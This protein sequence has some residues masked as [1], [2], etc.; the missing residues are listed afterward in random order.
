MSVSRTKC[1]ILHWCSRQQACRNERF[2]YT[3][4]HDCSFET[5]T[6]PFSMLCAP[7]W[8]MR[9]WTN[10]GGNH[11]VVRGRDRDRRLCH[12]AVIMVQACGL[13]VASLPQHRALSFSFWWLDGIIRAGPLASARVPRCGRCFGEHFLETESGGGVGK[14]ENRSTSPFGHSQERDHGD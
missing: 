5:I 4:Q 6:G 2:K 3:Y 9:L 10:G 14:L 13:R 7:N 11:F 8:K 12:L 1:Y